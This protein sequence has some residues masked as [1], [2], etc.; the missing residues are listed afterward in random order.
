[1]YKVAAFLKLIRWPNLVFIALTQLLFQYCLLQPIFQKSGITPV[2]SGTV[3]FII[4]IASVLIAAAG[5][6]INDY[7]DI[8]ID[9]I[10][11]PGR[12]FIPRYVT[13]RWAILWH[14]LLSFIGV[15]L[16]FYAGWKTGVWWIGPAN[17]LCA[18]LLFVYSTTFIQ[19]FLSG[20]VIIALLTAWTLAILGL[21]SF[22]KLYF[23]VA[24]DALIKGRILRFTILYASFAF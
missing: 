18:F 13:R 10:N 22:Y 21:A 17:V 1:M 14:S 20:N 4:L 2:I 16:S 9:Q 15:V 8:N 24:P 3:L 11:K 7:F 12:Q 23:T 19:R 6:I 5:Y